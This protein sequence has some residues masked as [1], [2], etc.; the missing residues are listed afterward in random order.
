MKPQAE[1]L[2]P[3]STIIDLYINFEGILFVSLIPVLVDINL[4]VCDRGIN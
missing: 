4:H 2:K 3:T 1:Q